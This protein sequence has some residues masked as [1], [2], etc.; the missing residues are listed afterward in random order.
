MRLRWTLLLFAGFL[1]LVSANIFCA[2]RIYWDSPVEFSPA[3]G[4]F[5]QTAYGQGIAVVGWQEAVGTA[6][7]GQIYVS[8]AVNSQ[9]NKGVW[10]RH[11][12]IAGPYRYVI[13]EPSIFT[14]SVDRRGRVFVCIAASTN[15]TEVLVSD[16]G[17]VNFESYTLNP[18]AVPA[19]DGMN[20]SEEINESLAPRIF[21][22]ADNSAVMFAL[23]SQ[24]RS[25]T[26]YHARSTDGYTWAP[27]TPFV[28]ESALQ[29]N[30][31]PAHAA[32]GGA[33]Y[34]V[35]QSLISGALNRPSYQL[36]LKTSS[37][38]GRTWSGARRITTFTDPF[39]ENQTNP[40][41][42]NNERA[43]LSAF[44]GSLFLVW[45]RRNGSGSPQI[46]GL[47][48]NRDGSPAGIAERINSR[49]TYCN[50]PIA[51]E[52]E[53]Q[54]VVI[55]FDNRLGQNEA[56]MAV[57]DGNTWQNTELSRFS[58]SVIFVRPALAGSTFHVFWQEITGGANRIYILSSDES[59]AAAQ[60]DA[61]NFIP[62]KRVSSEIA[63]I[64]WK[65]PYDSSGIRGYSW[66]WGQ[67]PEAV[68]PR[69]IMAPA[70]D[71]SVEGAATEDGAWYFAL[72][73]QDNADNWS[74]TSKLT[75]IRDTTPPPAAA[76]VPPAVDERG[77]L[78]SNT[79][80]IRWSEPPASDL[81]GYAWTLDYIAPASER[82]E[83]VML[84]TATA[85]SAPSRA[86][87]ERG[88]ENYASF[89]NEDDG[90]WRFSVAPMDD[91]GN[92]GPASSIVFRT[93]KYIPHTFITLLDYRQDVQGILSMS[94]IG[95]GFSE[96]GEVDRVFF[97]KDGRIVRE[98]SLENGD[99]TVHGDR[100]ISIHNVEL[101]PEGDYRIVVRHPLRG[102][103]ASPRPIS[104]AKT[105]TVKFGD[106][107]N[108]WKNSWI[109]QFGKNFV[110]DVSIALMLLLAV[111]CA[112][113]LLLTTR[114]IGVIMLEGRAVRVE[115]LALL[116]EELMP[117]EKK[118]QLQLA[119]KRILGLR[120]KFASFILALVLI[121]VT[122]LS[123]PLFMSMSRTQRETLMKGLWDRSSVLLE[124]LTRSSRVFMPSSSVLELGYLPA[125]IASVPEARYVTITGF[126]TGD[127]VNND[128]VWA[129]ND[130]DILTK[131]NTQVLELGVSR[132]TDDITPSVSML[133]EELNRE[134]QNAVG[135]MTESITQFNRESMALLLA[136]D[137]E[138]RL[139][140]EDLQVTTRDLENRITMMLDRIGS[141]ISSAPA[142]DIDNMDMNRSEN[143]LLYKPVMFRQSTSDI[144][145]RGIVR[146]E[147]SNE[148]ILAAI[149]DGQRSIIT[150]I[151]YVAVI[152]VAI[153]GVGAIVL[154]SLI[155][156]PIRR[157]VSHVE[158]IRDTEN[159]A[160][161]EGV[162]IVLK[163]NDELA[164]LANTINDMTHGLVKAAKAAEDL[165]I[166]K[167][168]QKK[169]IPLE[170]DKEGN[171]LTYGSQTTANTKFFGYYEG[172]K[173]VSG[174]YFDY[175]DIDGRYFAIIKCDVAGKGVPAALIMAQVATMFRNYFKTWTPTEEGMRIESLV[176][177]INDFIET[178]GFKGR[179]AAFT[180]CIFDSVNGLLRFCNA[181]DNLIHWYDHS[182]SK[183]KTVT[184]PQTPAVG[185]LPNTI[186]EAGNAYQIQT[187]KLDHG[188]M[189]LLY[190]DGIEEA[191]RLFRDEN[192]NEIVCAYDGLPNDSP[193]GS[194]VVGQNG[195]ELGADRVEEIINAVMNKRQYK[196]YKYHNPLG[197]VDYHFDFS[198]CRGT[199][200]EVIMAMVS[201]EK[202]FR[203]YN[204]PDSGSDARVLVDG[205]VN[206]FLRDYFLEYRIYCNP[207][208]YPGNPMYMYYTGMGEDEQY[209]DLT[210]LGLHWR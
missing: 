6:T 138:S 56:F 25:F 121:I 60:L 206:S 53:G 98:L 151:L 196:L 51:L 124:A 47:T 2:D 38:G 3:S 134:S 62:G 66:V 101:L 204:I 103:A 118:R 198:A 71:T 55:W 181:G 92:V 1:L 142:F 192:Y 87:R 67:D 63:R 48:L 177:L 133:N 168:I 161:L 113:L 9:T 57:K 147:I 128:Y 201:I 80:T 167:E 50:N 125:Q 149:R 49:V 41:G 83:A 105:F 4:S 131:I 208:D 100:E 107:T 5:P 81:S 190:T 31:L 130:P 109:V 186:L 26:L 85:G 74:E 152:A 184:L 72:I 120:L 34:V 91:I 188:D 210:I 119:K 191:K 16:E 32:I 174:D 95:R 23:R 70:Q 139:R 207:I 153:G 182:E 141:S 166:G 73:V 104:I 82:E 24:G 205:K 170:T 160:E 164:V 193:H 111:F 45:E 15:E 61:E 30:F 145:L 86:L 33:D 42:F 129:T 36:Y 136:T 197:E 132:I 126:G 94:I 200:E 97:R 117:A 140:L 163:T 202:I 59:A 173:G 76:I 7:S 185:V 172:A 10:M 102:E 96:S 79:F 69:T 21:H 144:Y 122:M 37:D 110:F 8:I 64:S 20:S 137:A 171:K 22:M 108:V 209:D 40:D 68:P 127:T 155:I 84:R 54:R 195:E 90:W 116:N 179:F 88:P 143:Y 112:F 52:F 183:L 165:S 43:H 178:L 13:N 203:L 35:F 17:G 154:S 162:E 180:L 157:L 19:P 189:L 44:S 175:Q 115:A 58:E 93:N 65:V 27:F 114:S 146:L 12:R 78:T 46:Y 176:Y 148:A 159:K 150:M 11:E 187:L 14:L 29:L 75:F 156:R 77:F 199:V 194:H 123:L 135:D 106:F 158:Q 99:Y 28:T 169:F 39:V 18:G 89:T